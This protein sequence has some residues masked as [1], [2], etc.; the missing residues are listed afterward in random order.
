[1]T[2]NYTAFGLVDELVCK[3]DNALAIFGPGEEIQFEFDALA[4]DPPVGW[5]RCFVFETR[6]WCKDMDLYTRDGETVGPLPTVGDVT[7]QR[8]RLHDR[9]HTRYESGW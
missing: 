4:E 9:Y 6:G 3:T 8:D 1:M 7:L 5:T 2:G